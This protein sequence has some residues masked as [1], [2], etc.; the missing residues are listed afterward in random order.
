[1]RQQIRARLYALYG[2]GFVFESQAPTPHQL[3]IMLPLPS[4]PTGESHA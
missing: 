2:E 1:L 4:I 3:R